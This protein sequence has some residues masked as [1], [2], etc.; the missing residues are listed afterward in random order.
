LRTVCEINQCAGCM[1]CVD[2]C[3]KGAITIQDSIESYNAIIDDTLCV[4]CGACYKICQSNNPPQFNETMEWFQGWANEQNIRE[5]SSSGGAATAILK[6]FARRGGIVCSC[7]MKDGIFGFEFTDYE[8]SIDQ[9]SGSKYVKSS[10]IGIYNKINEYLCEGKKVLF[11][12]LP[13]QV[14]AV[15]NYVVPKYEPNIFLV[16]LI[17]HGTPSPLVLDY[18]LNDYNLRINDLQ[19]IKFRKKDNFRILSNSDKIMSISP[20]G[21]QDLYSYSF[22]N[23]TIYTE[24]CYSCVYAQQKRVADIT[25]GDSWGS[26][27]SSDEKKKGIS[28]IMCQN[29]KGLRLVKESDLH[30]EIVDKDKS[31]AANRQLRVPSVAPLERKQ[32][33]H[34]LKMKKSFLNAF[35]R[36]YP[37][38]YIKF[39]IKVLLSKIWR[40]RGGYVTYSIYVVKKN[41]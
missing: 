32:F 19:D 38:K 14:A 3:P 15:K 20:N 7:M 10:P 16:E 26:D 29:E 41:R 13:C 5:N 36:V 22:L 18:F 1:A 9:F 30:L 21:T 27:L 11:L 39:K 12:G 24:N 40:V 28:L 34:I 17:C 25:L 31:I 2:R 4:E 35:S 37:R 23:C 8:G 6:Q 33:F